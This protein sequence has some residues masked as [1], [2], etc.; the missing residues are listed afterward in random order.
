MFGEF[1]NLAP[2]W[3]EVVSVGKHNYVGLTVLMTACTVFLATGTASITFQNVRY[4]NGYFSREK[5][6]I[7]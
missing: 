1:L 4:V 5:S 7:E 2:R 3:V 6:S